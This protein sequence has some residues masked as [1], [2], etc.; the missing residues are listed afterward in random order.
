MKAWA[1]KHLSHFISKKL[2]VFVVAT[3]YLASGYIDG[4][5]WMVIASVYIGGQTFIDAIARRGK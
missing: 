2:S 1:D 3:V 4:G 5:Q